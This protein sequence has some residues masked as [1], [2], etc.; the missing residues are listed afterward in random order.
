MAIYFDNS[1]VTIGN[2]GLQGE[3][4]KTGPKGDTGEQ[5]PQGIQGEKGD[6]GEAGPKGDK[7][8]AGPN[9]VST[10]TATNINGLMM[11]NGSTVQTATAGTDYMAPPATA[12][13]LPASGTALTANTIYNVS[14]TVGTYAFTA[15]SSGWAHGKFTTGSSTSVSF[16]GTFLGAAPSIEASKTYEFDVYD[17]VWAVAEVVSA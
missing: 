10:S 6:T 5:G 11:G 2:R 1:D 15:P 4:G 9:E 12:T 17:G 3:K 14:A 13:A 16:A 8:D 7:G